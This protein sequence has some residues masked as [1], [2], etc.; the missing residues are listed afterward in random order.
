MLAKHGIDTDKQ[1]SAHKESVT[2]QITLL[3]NQ[4]KSLRSQ[5]R[6]VRDTDRLAAVKGEIAALSERIGELRKEVRLC[7]DVER[8]SV[9]MRDKLR[10]AREAEKSEGKERTRNDPIRGRR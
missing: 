9:E 10:R 3:F 2:A 7:E 8:R 1:L 4:R 6:S 5:S